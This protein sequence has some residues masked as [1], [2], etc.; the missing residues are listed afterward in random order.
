MDS[1]DSDSPLPAESVLSR[2]KKLIL[3][4]SMAEFVRLLDQKLDDID[5][6]T[7]KTRGKR[8]RDESD[9]STEDHVAVRGD[10]RKTKKRAKR[11]VST[12]T[13]GNGGSMFACP[14]CK[15]DPDRYKTVKTCCGPGWI[16]VH[17]VKEHI[18]RRHSSKGF[19]HRC[20][21]HFEN[22]DELK[23]HQRKET[24]CKL[25]TVN[26]PEGITDEQEKQ[27]RARA[28][29]SCSEEE[30]WRDMYKII[31]PDTKVP[32]PFYDTIDSVVAS[33]E[34]KSSRFKDFD[35]FKEYVRREL[36]RLVKPI[37]EREVEILF[38][39]V[40]VKMKDRAAEILKD[41]QSR[42]FQTWQFQAEQS[43]ASLSPPDSEP[44]AAPAN[45]TTFPELDLNDFTGDP[46]LSGLLPNGFNGEIDLEALYSSTMNFPDCDPPSITDSGYKTWADGDLSSY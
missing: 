24:P 10:A 11:E 38:E 20:G 14:F 43:G 19:C 34:T 4:I 29:A 2:R 44:E 5:P 27:L 7:G 3:A 31:F 9:S 39:S 21:D 25:R 22:D 15:H 36:P 12:P 46:F 1:Y 18:Y 37:F 42:L 13:D 30:K 41:V 33:V 40:Q 45:I 6:K 16:N 17:R 26:V 8:A 23:R 28:K 35:E 32:S